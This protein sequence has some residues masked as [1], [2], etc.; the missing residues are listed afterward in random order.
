MAEITVREF[1]LALKHCY[2]TRCNCPK[3]PIHNVQDCFQFITKT[4]YEIIISQEAQIEKYKSADVSPVR[5]GRWLYEVHKENTNFRWNVTAEC[6]ECCDNRK[7][8][9]GGFFPNVPDCIARDVAL[10]SAKQIKL[11]NYCPHCGARMDGDG[12]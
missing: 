10:Q 4:A 11:D 2:M 5:H 6:S 12:E 9:W 3:C 1:E 7:E 8:I